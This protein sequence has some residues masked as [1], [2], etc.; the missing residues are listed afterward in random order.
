LREDLCHNES[1]R[2]LMFGRAAS[3]LASGSHQSK[4]VSLSNPSWHSV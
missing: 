1:S 3:F 2:G 4:G